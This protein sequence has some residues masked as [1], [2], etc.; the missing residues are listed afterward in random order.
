MFPFKTLRFATN[1]IV[2]D[3]RTSD[4]GLEQSFACRGFRVTALRHFY[5]FSHPQY[6]VLCFMENRAGIAI[7]SSFS[8]LQIISSVR[9]LLALFISCNQLMCRKKLKLD[10][11]DSSNFCGYR[12]SRGQRN[13]PYGRI[14][15]FLDR[16][17][18][19]FF[20]VSPQLYS[21]G[22][23]DPVPDPL[24][25]RRSGSAG[26]RARTSGSVARNSDHWTTEASR[27]QLWEFPVSLNALDCQRSSANR[28]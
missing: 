5:Q 20:Q 22:S 14:F 8:K 11:K 2:R 24:L 19:F 6:S 26:N 4:I 3:P 16:N 28:C 23:V 7:I 1:K 17:R 9:I 15:D 12:A 18:Y 27:Q 25:L 21:R 13:D 10:G